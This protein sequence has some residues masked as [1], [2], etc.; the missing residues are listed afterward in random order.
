MFKLD[1]NCAI[2]VAQTKMI[3]KETIVKYHV[4]QLLI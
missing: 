2:F 3:R 4:V 1:G